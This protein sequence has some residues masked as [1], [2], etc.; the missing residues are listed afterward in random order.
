MHPVVGLFLA[1]VLVQV[2]SGCCAPVEGLYPPADGQ[3]TRQIFVVD[4]HWHT[5]LILRTADLSPG[6]KAKLPRTAGSEYVEFGW[7]D[8]GFYRASQVTSGLAVQAM[9]FSQG[10]VLHIQTLASAP[11]AHYEGYIV[12]IYR[13]R[14]SDAGFRNLTDYL[15]AS[16]ASDP[17]GQ[18][19][20]LGP[21]FMP[22]SWFYRARGRYSVFHTCNQW[23][24]D[25]LRT[26]GFPITAFYA[27]TA[28][29]VAFQ[30]G[31]GA[32]AYEKNIL[33]YSGSS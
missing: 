23:T 20:E 3:A 26:T 15:E 7:G 29:N 31:M 32:K 12:D 18:S 2:C 4:N 22:T 21:G 11:A 14:V 5:G 30:L 16:F 1:W 17:A 6:L 8:E 25:A 24:A 19:E 33:L 28:S 27:S 10:T 9:F 13:L